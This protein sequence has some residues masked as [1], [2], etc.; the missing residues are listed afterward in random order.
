MSGKKSARATTA[1][2]IK[3]PEVH[4]AEVTV[5]LLSCEKLSKEEYMVTSGPTNHLDFWIIL[6]IV[7]EL[8]PLRKVS[9]WA[10]MPV[11]HAR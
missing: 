6:E 1:F 2:M 11:H 8:L 7:K 3:I 4:D 9:H 5:A 10:N